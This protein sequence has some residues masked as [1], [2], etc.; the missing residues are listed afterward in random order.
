MFLFYFFFISSCNNK[1]IQHNMLFSASALLSSVLSS[2]FC[3]Y[4]CTKK[5][6]NS[7]PFLS[8]PSLSLVFCALIRHTFHQLNVKFYFFFHFL[9][10]SLEFHRFVYWKPFFCFFCFV[11]MRKDFFNYYSLQMEMI[12]LWLVTAKKNIILKNYYLPKDAII[13]IIILVIISNQNFII[14]K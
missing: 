12:W 6:T 5:K 14:L 9:L 2:Q 13:M 1:L 11:A 4:C 10:F 7:L 3:Y 8:F